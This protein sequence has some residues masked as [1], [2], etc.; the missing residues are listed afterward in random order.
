[1]YYS[2]CCNLASVWNICKNQSLNRQF[3]I[4][5]FEIGLQD[6][7]IHLLWDLILKKQK[8]KKNPLCF[9]NWRDS[10]HLG[11][12]HLSF[13]VV[14]S[15]ANSLFFFLILPSCFWDMYMVADVDGNGC[16]SSVSQICIL[17]LLIWNSLVL[18]S[19]LLSFSL[20][21]HILFVWCKV[22]WVFEPCVWKVAPSAMK[23][24][25]I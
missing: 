5:I 23:W 2:F 8:P 20:Y 7:C 1:M 24:Q 19:R 4:R 11:S 18:D 25:C 9:Q 17:L 15:C 10:C 22:T 14:A 6:S 3:L 16:D 21:F 12:S 13:W